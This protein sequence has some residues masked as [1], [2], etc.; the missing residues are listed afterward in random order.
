MVHRPPDT[1][2]LNNLI[3]NE[4]SYS[5]HLHS[6]LTL[7]SSSQ[8]A[9]SAYASAS[10]QDL[11]RV[12]VNVAACLSGADDALADYAG[13]V[14]EW[15]DGLARI[16]S[17]EEELGLILRDRE[18]FVTRLLKASKPQK[19]NRDSLI[20]L[21]L[22]NIRAS[23]SETS[24]SSPS[25]HPASSPSSSTQLTKLATAQAELQACEGHLARK[26]L[27]LEHLR[28]SIVRQGL[29]GRLRA[30]IRCAEIW[31]VVGGEGLGVLGFGGHEKVG[32][33]NGHVVIGVVGEEGV[34]VVV[35]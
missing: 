32:M 21:G 34:V 11:A 27:E 22:S 25:H 13:A 17:A 26:E 35:G 8:A 29:E 12:I 31:R 30:L 7:S 1:R 33:A 2:L 28:S 5:K 10:S 18:I 24:L 14:D 6:L 20:N 19:A 15:R 23:L 3:T 16:K 9:F 4:L